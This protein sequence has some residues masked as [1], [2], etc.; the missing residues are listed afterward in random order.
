MSG[1][2]IEGAGIDVDE[3]RA[4]AEACDA[5]GRGEKREGRSD[6]FVARADA[7]CHE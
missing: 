4:C 1:I 2:E 5:A 3:D 7:K 6:D